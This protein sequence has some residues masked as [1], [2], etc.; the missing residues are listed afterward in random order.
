NRSK[1]ICSAANSED[2]RWAAPKRSTRNR[3]KAADAPISSR[4][5]ASGSGKPRPK[6]TNSTLM[7]CPPTASQRSSTRV[8]SRSGR[9]L[10]GR[11][12]LSAAEL[13]DI[14]DSGARHSERFWAFQ[15]KKIDGHMLDPTPAGTTLHPFV[16]G[17]MF[18]NDHCNHQTSMVARDHRP[19]GPGL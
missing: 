17:R 10:D 11:G 16:T 15:D 14:G 1:A 12:R 18:R 7:V 13:K 19:H 9:Q 6:A 2:G 8:S 3:L 4:H 5:S